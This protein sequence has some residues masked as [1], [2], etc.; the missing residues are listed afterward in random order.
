[1]GCSAMGFRDSAF[2]SG[3]SLP[4]FFLLDPCSRIFVLMNFLAKEEMSGV[5]QQQ[6]NVHEG[7]INFLGN[8]NT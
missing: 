8:S 4:K 2:V 1:M 6:S 5:T 3:C 7:K